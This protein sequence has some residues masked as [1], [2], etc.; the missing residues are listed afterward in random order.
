M[1]DRDVI[2]FL[3]KSMRKAELARTLGV[4]P[5]MVQNWRARGIA[6]SYRL[7]IREMANRKGAKLPVDWLVQ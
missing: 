3:G 4:T 2:D 5:Q 1:T 6:K 7:K